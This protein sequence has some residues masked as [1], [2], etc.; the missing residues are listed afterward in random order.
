MLALLCQI[1]AMKTFLAI[2]IFTAL[3][4]CSSVSEKEPERTSDSQTLETPLPVT[5][6]GDTL[7]TPSHYYYLADQNQ[8]EI[9]RLILEGSLQ[10]ADNHVTFA[11]MDSLSSANK[12]TR[13]FVFPAFKV[14][15]E[16]SDGALSEVVGLYAIKYL[17]AYP[18]EFAERYSCC[19]EEL[20]QL[21]N[22]IGYEIMMSQEPTSEYKQ[23]L[24]KINQEYPT[25]EQDKSIRAFKEKLEA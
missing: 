13:D 20:S 4:S 8:Q 18:K 25:Y 7:R 23:L 19:P 21:T 6:E 15:V 9:I 24:E 3:F 14:V 17:E 16:K 12:A 2:L 22:Y 1:K 11:L 10:P 5:A